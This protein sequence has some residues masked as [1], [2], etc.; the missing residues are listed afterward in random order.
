MTE[1]YLDAKHFVAALADKA[2][3]LRRSLIPMSDEARSK[4][5]THLVLTST[6]VF[7][8][9]P[10][11]D[12]AGGIGIQIIK[13]EDVLVPLDGFEMPDG[14]SIVAIPCVG[15]EQAT[16]ARDAWIRYHRRR[17]E[18]SAQAEDTSAAI[19]QNSRSS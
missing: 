10:D 7:G 18:I 9:W 4:H 15:Y 2:E 6:M 12:E 19:R 8:V 5:A 3:A 14:I 17:A 16:A 1:T 13:G 11:T